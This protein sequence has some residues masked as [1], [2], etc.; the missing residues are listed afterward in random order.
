MSWKKPFWLW[1][2]LGLAL[3]TGLAAYLVHII[4]KNENHAYFSEQIA[5]GEWV[6]VQN[7]AKCHGLYAEGLYPK[8]PGGGKNARGSIIAP[9][10]NGS[11]H[12]GEHPESILF[13]RIRNG[14]IEE[15]TM[16]HGFDRILTDKE[17]LN[18]IHYLRSLWQK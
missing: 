4:I 15:D 18:V 5:K 12:T 3:I 6:Y 2:G 9:A 7:F 8:L 11:G 1:G 17:I 10:L 16:M 14:S 13:K